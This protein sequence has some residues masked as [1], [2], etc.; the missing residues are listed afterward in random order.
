MAAIVYFHFHTLQRTQHAPENCDH[1]PG[2]NE[3]HQ[4]NKQEQRQDH[5]GQRQH[6]YPGQ[7]KREAEMEDAPTQLLL[8]GDAYHAADHLNASNSRIASCALISPRLSRSRISAREGVGL[9]ST[10]SRLFA[11][12]V[13]RDFMVG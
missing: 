10:N 1:S 3:P 11:I 6:Q 13:S 7:P 2:V 12:R 5:N 9:V 4:A 8:N